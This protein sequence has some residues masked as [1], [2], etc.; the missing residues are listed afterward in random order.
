MAAAHRRLAA[1]RV[2]ADEDPAA[3]LSAAYYAMLYAARAALSACPLPPDS[4]SM[5]YPP[6]A[7][8]R[9][10]SKRAVVV[11]ALRPRPA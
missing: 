10:A 8:S 4:A 1:A 3:A 7:S 11:R 2:A 5:G 9:S 6:L